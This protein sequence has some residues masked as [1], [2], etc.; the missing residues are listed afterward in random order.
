MNLLLQWLAQQ[1]Q[2]STDQAQPQLL[3]ILN[4]DAGLG[5]TFGF[6]WGTGLWGG[7]QQ[8]FSTLE[9]SIY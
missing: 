9:W 8:V 7:G 1:G 6:G 2:R 5:S 4:Q 3:H